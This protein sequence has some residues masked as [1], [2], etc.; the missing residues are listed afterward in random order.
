MPKGD[1]Y[2]ELSNFLKNSHSANVHLSFDEIQNIIGF[3]LPNSAFSPEY[4]WWGNDKSHSQAVAWMGAG[5][6]VEV[7]FS[8]RIASFRKRI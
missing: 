6:V 4:S 3:K 1:K 8:N 5:Y 7:S 2:I